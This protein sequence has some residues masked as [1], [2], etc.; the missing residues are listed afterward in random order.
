MRISG[1]EKSRGFRGGRSK[2]ALGAEPVQLSGLPFDLEKDL[3]K[4]EPEDLS[5]AQLA[6]LS[7]LKPELLPLVQAK[8]GPNHS[9][10]SFPG[11]YSIED[12]RG[13]FSFTWLLWAAD[14]IQ[15][16]PELRKY[17]VPGLGKLYPSLVYEQI[18]QS[19]RPDTQ[20]PPFELNLAR[21]YRP[22]L[23]LCPEKRTEILSSMDASQLHLSV[24][25]YLNGEYEEHTNQ[26]DLDPKSGWVQGFAAAKVLFP[27]LAIRI[28][29]FFIPHWLGI[30][31][32]VKK[33]KD[34]GPEPEYVTAVGI[35]S[36]ESAWVDEQGTFHLKFADKRPLPA[37]TPLPSRLVG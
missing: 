14:N 26:F 35:L 15:A 29:E 22:F 19:V 6:A 20:Q 8:A 28:N 31:D 27:D 17:K 11:N 21:Y 37:T 7:C 34:T 9:F 5:S 33:M 12:H 32:R 30:R 13:N 10:E 18:Q 4:W 36:A 3:P 24:E 25:T 16:F 23:E 2:E 1:R